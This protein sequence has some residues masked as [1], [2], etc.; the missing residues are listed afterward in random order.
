M[1]AA[2]M[3]SGPRVIEYGYAAAMRHAYMPGLWIAKQWEADPPLT[4]L[5]QYRN[6]A[7]YMRSATT[8]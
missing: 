3:S 1:F 2:S 5:P 7:L 6:L 4:P 8:A